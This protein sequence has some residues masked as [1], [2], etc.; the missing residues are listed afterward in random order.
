VFLV[1]AVRV[2]GNIQLAS[3]G[4][5]W[6]FSGGIVKVFEQNPAFGHDATS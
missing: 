1:V 2:L 5:N 6:Y 4:H 3:F